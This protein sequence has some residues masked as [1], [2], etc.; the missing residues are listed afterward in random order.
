MGMDRSNRICRYLLAC[1]VALATARGA[2]A[3]DQTLV[4]KVRSHLRRGKAEAKQSQP[5]PGIPEPA[6]R[7]ASS[8]QQTSASG[9]QLSTLDP[10][11]SP[12]RHLS[13]PARRNSEAL[14][15]QSFS[16]TLDALEQLTR[17]NNPT[18]GQAAAIVEAARGRRIQ[19]GLYPNPT[20]GY[21]GSEIGND[22]RGGQ[23]GIVVGQEI[24][25]AGKLQ[26]SEAVAGHEFRQAEQQATA[27][28][29]RVLT[30]VR[31]LFYETLAA[32]QTMSLSRELVKLAEQGVFVAQQ[33]V[34]AG[35]GTLTESLQAQ[36]ELAQVQVIESNSANNYRATWKQL[37]A[38]IG[39][40]DWEPQR[41]A[42]SLEGLQAGRDEQ[43]GFGKLATESP[44]VAI[45]KFGVQR[46]EAAVARARVESV[47]NLTVEAGTQYD[48]GS[49]TQ[50]ANVGI[51]LPI[52]VF[53][54]NQ[55]NIL[56]AE[57]ELIR[58]HRE[59]D[60]V[61]LSLAERFAPAFAR[62]RNAHQQVERYGTRLTEDEVNKILAL[63][64]E[65]RQKSLEAR[66]QI[67]PRA[68]I[69]LALA[70]EGWQRGEFNYLQV[71]TAQRTLTQATLIYVRSLT[72]LRQS[73]VNLDG[74]L[75]SDGLNAPGQERR[76]SGA[77]SR[78]TS[79]D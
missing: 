34:K 35:E 43:A 29:I 73:E 48:F 17:E 39:L 9:P 12:G 67:L 41:L 58:S 76:G 53:N 63:K 66:P 21:T 26:L 4:G 71:L 55:G 42:G 50:I 23:Q 77:G 72:E 25:R 62:Y 49:E 5:A 15:S 79:E 28:M 45:A 61:K 51:S 22:G 78:G 57:S 52:P 46:A 14:D 54:R 37:A 47:P 24:V 19:A 68:Q 31:S 3:D 64:G 38:M 1:C 60:R 7:P 10:L 2:V 13:S 75:L 32:E 70:T 27:Q 74:F 65:E 40:P 30:T 44:E 8:I 16:L 69:A 18:L 56:S 6:I 11:P 36:I 20:I 33:R 59:V